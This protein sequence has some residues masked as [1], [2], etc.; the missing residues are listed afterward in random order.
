MTLWYQVSVIGGTAPE[1][2]AEEGIVAFENGFW[3]LQQYLNEED[4]GVYPDVLVMSNAEDHTWCDTCGK[5]DCGITHE[6]PPTTPVCD[7][8]GKENCDGVH[9]LCL[10]CG[11]MNCEKEHIF[12]GYCVEYDCGIDHA[13]DIK[14]AIS[15]VIPENPTLT[16]GAAVSIVDEYGDPVTDEGFYLAEGTKASLSAWGNLK[17][18]S[19]QW[20]ICYDPA[21]D[22]WVNVPGA[23][24]KGILV[25]TA[26]FCSLEEPA[27][28]CVMSS[29]EE[30]K[31]SGSIP[32]V[33]VDVPEVVGYTA[34]TTSGTSSDSGQTDQEQADTTTQF[35]LTIKYILSEKC[36]AAGRSVAIDYVGTYTT[37]EDVAISVPHPVVPGYEPVADSNQ[38]IAE[39]KYEYTFPAGQ[40]GNVEVTVYY[41]PAEVNY[42]VVHYVQGVDDN[43]YTEVLRETKTGITEQQVAENMQSPSDTGVSFAGLHPLNY[44]RPAIAA[45]G[46]TVIEIY[47]DRIYYLISFELDGGYGVDPVFDRFGAEMPNVGEPTHAG[48]TFAGWDLLDENGQGDGTADTLPNTIPAGNR[49]YRAIWSDPQQVNVTIVYWRE[50][51]DDYGFSVWGQDTITAQAGSVLDGTDYPVPDSVAVSDSNE[52][53]YF[54]LNATKTDKNVTILGDGST[55]INVYYNRN[56]YSVYFYAVGTCGIPEHTHSDVLREL[57]CTEDHAHDPVACYIGCR[58][59]ICEEDHEHDETNCYR[60]DCGMTVHTHS[61]GSNCG[62]FKDPAGKYTTALPLVH[63]ITAKYN[64]DISTIWPMPDIMAQ[65]P[66]VHKNSS[67]EAANNSGTPFRAWQVGKKS[68]D[69]TV[70]KRLVMSSGL[71]DVEDGIKGAYALYKTGTTLHLH[72]MVESF[73]QD[74]P[75][76][77]EV[78]T[79]TVRRCFDGK[80]YD[81]M[82]VHT[83]TVVAATTGTVDSGTFNHKSIDG[84]SFTDDEA[85]FEYVA[86]REYN[87]FLYYSRND[88][89]LEF[90]NVND[91]HKLIGN[92]PYGTPL[93][94]YSS[95]KP[96]LPVGWEEGVWSFEGWYTTSNCLDGTK[97]SFDGDDTMP[98][99][100]LI[101]YAKW[102]PVTH[103]VTFHQTYED[104]LS[105]TPLSEKT[106]PT[107]TVSHGYYLDRI[108]DAVRDGYYFVNWFYIDEK[109]KEEKAFDPDNMPVTSDMKLYAKW[110]SSVTVEYKI[111]FC[112]MQDGVMVD[113]A[114][115]ITNKSLAGQTITY[116]AKVGGALYPAYQ[117]YYFPQFES[118]SLTLSKDEGAV[119][120]IVFMYDQVQ[121]VTYTVK[122]LNKETGTNVFDGTT[123]DSTI[124]VDSMT[125]TTYEAAVTE[126]YFP[127]AGYIPDESRKTLILTTSD[128]GE[129]NILTF[130]Y[131]KANNE[132]P[133]R[134]THYIAELNGGWSE[135]RANEE[136][137]TFGT[138]YS[139]NSLIDIPGFTYS[140]EQTENHQKSQTEGTNVAVM[141]DSVSGTLVD[142][143]GL[144][145][146]LYY[147]RNQYPYLVRYVEDGSYNTVAAPKSG[148]APYQSLVTE[149]AIDVAGYTCISTESQTITIKIEEGQ[150][151]VLNVITFKY[152]RNMSALKISKEVIATPVGSAPADDVFEFTV[153]LNGDGS[154]ASATFPQPMYRYDI[155]NIGDDTTVVASGVVYP[156]AS[157][158]GSTV[159]D[160]FKVS[161]KAGQYALL[162]GVPTGSYTITEAD[163]T[164]KNYTTDY[165]VI[166]V[167]L[168]EEQTTTAAFVNRYQKPTLDLTIT[169]TCA[170]ANQS[171]IFVVSGIPYDTATF[172]NTISLEVVL[173]GNDSQ[174]I[175]DLPIG[176]YTVTEKHSWSWRQDAVSGSVNVGLVDRMIELKTQSGVE[177]T[178]LFGQAENNYWL[179]GCSS[180]VWRK[181]DEVTEEGGE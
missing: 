85:T 169:T 68:S 178:F 55:I 168:V 72:Y 11:A 94:T 76:N 46:S 75:E 16:D 92:I 161:L 32:V 48:Y 146:D 40:T 45:D 109:T 134:R 97:Y 114:A 27:L 70:S 59:L 42:L 24:E 49:K 71:C 124:T 151:A 135:Y 39:E 170:D 143:T 80:Y 106:H 122:Y 175:K 14:P 2:N 129:E 131:T 177:V 7:T 19:Y 181:E 101:L 84:L 147:T 96:S 130:W 105:D 87:Y 73:D 120:E 155:Y 17:G 67:G 43:N 150:E 25:S 104:M 139:E 13:A 107:K 51:A 171:F 3:I 149:A 5:Y 88:Y 166:D 53:P 158:S 29:G 140:K 127:I 35:K 34:R 52:S 118:Q 66:T 126:N 152:E 98:A 159:K 69:P 133:V 47:Y 62:T 82:P 116:N 81:V 162:K 121:S 128:D 79:D 160:M 4:A 9:L 38:N 33:L 60:Y 36:H 56:V 179:S 99:G 144:Y 31:V 78:K 61:D 83:Q 54:T 138:P 18:A 176:K 93:S 20:Q 8:C 50:N 100:G 156:T 90:Y 37:T 148:S 113:I 77:T 15:A 180:Y 163:Y 167:T 41:D 136:T 157:T 132:G 112:T 28:R 26:L 173:V 30:T 22:L 102:V 89:D 174:T 165:S 21:N 111:R 145:L 119:N 141:D 12:C 86:Y 142:H 164:A 123:E 153:K 103:T 95:E 74:S 110:T 108:N 23:D 1:E 115:P 58:I 117:T 125:V 44:E 10:A 63:A 154:D 172:G 6:T 91:T 64:A 57:T 65:L 137:G